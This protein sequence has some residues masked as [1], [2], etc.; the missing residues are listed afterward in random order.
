M[1]ARDE[2][3]PA[4]ANAVARIVEVEVA[5]RDV[6][7]ASQ[8]LASAFG[9]VASVPATERTEGLEV[10]MSAL[11]LGGARLGFIQDATG[12]GPVARFL[13][14]RGEGIYSVLVVVPNL[15]EAMA[16]MR[17]AGIRLFPEQPQV[18]EH[19]ERDGERF[20]KI[21]IVWTHPTTT[22]GVLI[23]LQERE[24]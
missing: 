19:V 10:T 9:T 24:R 3:D 20:S 14:K 17:K 6:E 12:S 7:A 8:R 1:Q 21:S 4:A 16:R 5:V 23:E 18:L 2:S 22:H 15:S 13:E 11:T